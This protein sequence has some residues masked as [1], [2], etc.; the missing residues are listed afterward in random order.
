MGRPK[1]HLPFGRSTVLGAAV[2]AALGA[3][4]RV[5]VVGRKEDKF[6]ASYAIP[7]RVLV[8][9]NPEPER[10]MLSSLHAGL[11]LAAN[12][13]EARSPWAKGEVL[14]HFRGFFFAP[15]DM[16][17]IR[18]STYESLLAASENRPAIAAFRGRRGHPVFIPAALSRALRALPDDGNL[19]SLID[20]SRP[21]L[22]ETADEGTV[23]DIDVP[24]D[25]ELAVAQ[26]AEV[27]TL[28]TSCIPRV[29]A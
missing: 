24:M 4:L 23:T 29:E 25:Y 26:P 27:G 12:A 20:A 7:G 8:A 2:E 28:S 18:A 6:I 17:L 15:G 22:V 1:L 10:G 5:V 19:R 16:P 13:L 21:I 3:G 9:I 14:R 11:D